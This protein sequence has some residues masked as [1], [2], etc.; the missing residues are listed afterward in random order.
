MN[1]HS[2]EDFIIANAF[3]NHAKSTAVQPNPLRQSA[4]LPANVGTGANRG[5]R[6]FPISHSSRYAATTLIKARIGEATSDLDRLAEL[7]AEAP[8]GWAFATGPEPD[9]GVFVVEMEG[10]LGAN[11]FNSLVALEISCLQGEDSDWQ[12][13]SA[14]DGWRTFAIY[15]FPAGMILRPNGKHPAP[16][17]TI[18][19]D[20]DYVLLPPDFVFLDSDV[21]IASGPA[22]LLDLAFEKVSNEVPSQVARRIAPQRADSRFQPN[23]SNPGT[24]SQ[25][26]GVA[27][28]GSTVSSTA[29]WRGKVRISRRS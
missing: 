7:A 5:L 17:L 15:S 14:G 29:G 13:L 11:A 23:N 3:L 22:L 28:Y 1:F 6:I 18:H 2:A 16:G 9:A 25:I 27:R 20:G 24:G 21:K 19:G 4:E 10:E 8:A 26:W 12:T